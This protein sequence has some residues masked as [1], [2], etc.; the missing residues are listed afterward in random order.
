MRPHRTFHRRLPDWQRECIDR[1]WKWS[2]PWGVF[3]S[4]LLVFMVVATSPLNQVILSELSH[5][6]HSEGRLEFTWIPAEERHRR[7]WWGTVSWLNGN[8]IAPGGRKDAFGS[9]T[10][11]YPRRINTKITPIVKLHLRFPDVPWDE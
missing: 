5:Y 2:L 4:S 10:H 6:A 9:R 8:P 7:C 1:K 11:A 3:S